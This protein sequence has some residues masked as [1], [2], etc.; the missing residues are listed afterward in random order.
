MNS[1]KHGK[2]GKKHTFRRLEVKIWGFKTWCGGCV[3]NCFSSSSQSPFSE[4]DLPPCMKSS[5]STLGDW[6]GVD[7]TELISLIFALTFGYEIQCV[8]FLELRWCKLNSSLTS[9]ITSQRSSRTVLQRWKG[10]CSWRKIETKAEMGKAFCLLL[11]I[12]EF[13][14]KSFLGQGAALGC[15]EICSWPWIPTVN[16][17]G[18]HC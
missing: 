10:K 15:H 8:V 5:S 16:S 4:R 6:L 9:L 13:G 3:G 7:V 11:M 14:T 18:K 2:R 12:F 17:L 1:N